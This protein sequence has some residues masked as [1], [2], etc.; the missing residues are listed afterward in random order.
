MAADEFAEQRVRPVRAAAELG[1]ELD[2]DEER[3]VFE[4][5]DFDQLAV[6][7]NAA[8]N[9]SGPGQRFA[10][11]VV[12][13]KAMP[14]ALGNGGRA[15]GRGRFGAGHQL[16]RPQTEPHGAAHLDPALPGIRSIT[17]SLVRGSIRTNARRAIPARWRAIS[18]TAMCNP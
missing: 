8:G 17:A 5:H 14:V 15:V 2:A 12:D 4:L 3:M 13:L 10:I 6:G 1:M 18:I 16:A 7:R 9:Q 11:I